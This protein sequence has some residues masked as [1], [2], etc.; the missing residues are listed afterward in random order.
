[1]TITATDYAQ[2][3]NFIFKMTNNIKEV[4][5]RIVSWSGGGLS[6][7]TNDL[8]WQSTATRRPG[9]TITFNDLNLSV[10][11]D[12]EFSSYESAFD[13]I[14]LFKDSESGIIGDWGDNSFS[15]IL[16]TTD[17]RNRFNKVFTFSNCW[18]SS[19][20]D[21][22]FKTSQQGTEVMT[23]SLTVIFDYYVISDA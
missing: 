8:N 13:F 17:N 1:M 3:A 12:E 21:L 5:Y 10:L 7:G 6:L 9:S 2:E 23:F 18:F 16:M 22:S 4:E 11:I 20:G 19:M 15:G 14:K